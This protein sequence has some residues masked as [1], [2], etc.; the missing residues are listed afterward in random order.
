MS[1]QMR[2]IGKGSCLALAIS[3]EYQA[4]LELSAL[5]VKPSCATAD[6]LFT[7]TIK[8]KREMH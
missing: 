4:A 5:L 2:E 7:P 3:L 6:P 1:V 8:K